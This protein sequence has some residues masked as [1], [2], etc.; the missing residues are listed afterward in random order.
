[1]G[2]K[3][4]SMSAWDDAACDDGVDGDSGPLE[5][6]AAPLLRLFR[7][8]CSYLRRH[9]KSSPLSG[10][11][12]VVGCVVVVVSPIFCL[13]LALTVCRGLESLIV[14]DVYFHTARRRWL[15]NVEPIG[16]FVWYTLRERARPLFRGLGFSRTRTPIN[17]TNV[18]T[19]M[20]RAA[21]RG[22]MEVVAEK[23]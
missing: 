12:G 16:T 21:A 19:F 14:C 17:F 18:H 5:L 6:I 8:A 15:Q 20:V 22:Q 11:V 4:K 3:I 1:M 7:T 13:R 2:A 9:S 10:V 23:K